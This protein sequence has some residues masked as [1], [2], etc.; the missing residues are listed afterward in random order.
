[1]SFSKKKNTVYKLYKRKYL[2][3]NDL[4]EKYSISDCLSPDFINLL[5]CQLESK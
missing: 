4:L 5:L 3:G 2:F 1:M